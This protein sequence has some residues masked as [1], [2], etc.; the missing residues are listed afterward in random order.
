MALPFPLSPLRMAVLISGG[1]TTLRNLLEQIDAGQLDAVVDVVVSSNP[2]AKGLQFAIERGIPAHV[3]ARGDYAS[4]AE[5]SEAI[6]SHCR[7]AGSHLVVMGGFLKLVRIPPDF[8]GRVVNIHP[9]L[10]PS[11]CGRG[12][13]GLAVHQAVLDY[14]C[15]I[16]GCTVH[17]V[18]NEYDHGP[19]ISQH[20][21]PVEG[22]DTAETLAARVFV[23]ECTAYPEA[24]RLFA[25]G[26]LRI[27]GRRV[28][29]SK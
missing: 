25:A 3:C 19:V 27:Q 18:D 23:A 28:E 26:A 13:Y 17:F 16:S 14:G 29:I 11:F 24:L 9:G 22:G 12:Y 15:K 4:T 1:G 5:F 2:Q 21:V 8:A 20:C 10:I 7:G 6:F